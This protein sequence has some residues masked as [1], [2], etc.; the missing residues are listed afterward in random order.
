V[1]KWSAAAN[2]YLRTPQAQEHFRKSYLRIVGGSSADFAAHHRAETVRWGK[3]VKATG[4]QA[5]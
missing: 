1:Q 3:L 4:I 5:Q 2:E